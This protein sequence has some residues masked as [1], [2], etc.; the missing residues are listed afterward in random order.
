MLKRLAANLEYNAVQIP[1][2]AD[3]VYVKT[4]SGPD[5]TS[6]DDAWLAINVDRLAIILD[7]EEATNMGL[8]KSKNFI[9][10][11]TKGYYGINGYHSLHCLVW[12]LSSFQ[13]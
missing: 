4:P 10:D 12:K 7:H 8:E 5:D 11:E 1:H 3:N 2:T 9:W 13:L 6:R